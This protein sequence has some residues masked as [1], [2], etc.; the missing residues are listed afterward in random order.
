VCGWGAADHTRLCR[1]PTEVVSGWT[2][3]CHRGQAAPWPGVERALHAIG[4]ILSLLV[5]P[6]TPVSTVLSPASRPGA[7]HQVT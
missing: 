2:G 4:W 6:Y 1:S 5:A 3:G 7:E